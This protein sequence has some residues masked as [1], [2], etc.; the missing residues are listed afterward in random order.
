MLAATSYGPIT[1]PSILDTIGN[2]T[3]LGSGAKILEL[4]ATNFISIAIS[5]AG[6]IA[7][8][9]FLIGGY[10]YLT[11]GGDK[12]A[13]QKSTKTITSAFI[14]LAIIISLFAIISLLEAFFGIHIFKFTIPVIT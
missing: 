10:Q 12:E 3:K 1:N 7:F 5:F 13:V 14:G 6:I 8:F 9:M 2:V 4:F 11:S